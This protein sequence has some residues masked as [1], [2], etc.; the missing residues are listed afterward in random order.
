LFELWK[1]LYE[2]KRKIAKAI[3]RSAK[4]P[5]KAKQP[6]SMDQ[7]SIEYWLIPSRI[8]PNGV[9]MVEGSRVCI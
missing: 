8:K 7:I 4:A 3:K 5:Q 6:L 9:T 1:D 2:T